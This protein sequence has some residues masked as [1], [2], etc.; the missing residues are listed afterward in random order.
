MQPV[1]DLNSLEYCPVTVTKCHSMFSLN[2][3]QLPRNIL[4]N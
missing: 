4:V 2:P 1:Y 3:P